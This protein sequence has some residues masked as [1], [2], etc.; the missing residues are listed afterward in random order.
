MLDHDVQRRQPLRDRSLRGRLLCCL[1]RRRRGLQRG[2]LYR[3]GM[4]HEQLRTTQQVH[5]RH[6]S[7]RMLYFSLLGGSHLRDRHLPRRL[8]QHPV[9]R[10]G[11]VHYRQLPDR[12]MHHR[13]PRG[14]DLQHRAV[15]LK[16]RVALR[17]PRTILPARD[18]VRVGEDRQ[19]RPRA[20]TPIQ[21]KP[22]ARP[23]PP[24]GVIAPNQRGAPSPIA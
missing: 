15:C 9:R 22:A 13:M 1:R 16:P 7:G 19:R 4:W 17:C 8:L 3:W 24:S 20:R 5:H 23:T 6:L 11:Y 21:R 18:R 14:R 12:G 2:D 10:G